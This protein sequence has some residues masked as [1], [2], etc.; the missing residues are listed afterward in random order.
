MRHQAT[1]ISRWPMA[2]EAKLPLQHTLLFIAL[3]FPRM[4]P[5]R[6]ILLNLSSLSILRT[7]PILGRKLVC[8]ST[9]RLDGWLAVRPSDRASVLGRMIC[10]FAPT[11]KRRV[12]RERLSGRGVALLSTRRRKIL[13]ECHLAVLWQCF[14]H[15]QAPITS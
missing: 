10:T 14:I 9:L 6:E 2:F 8:P 1:S 5:P 3:H 7:S 4:S 11:S 12:H 13:T 15:T